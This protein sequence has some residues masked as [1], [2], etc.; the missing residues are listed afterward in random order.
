MIQYICMDD[1]DFITFIIDLVHLSKLGASCKRLGIRVVH[2]E[3]NLSKR[4]VVHER[5]LLASY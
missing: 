5:T 2:A 4:G 1:I 3:H